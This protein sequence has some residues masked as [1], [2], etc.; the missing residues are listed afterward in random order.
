[1]VDCR[2]NRLKCISGSCVTGEE[3]TCDRCTF[4]N[5]SGDIILNSNNGI[6]IRKTEFVLCTTTFCIAHGYTL[7]QTV[8]LYKKCKSSNYLWCAGNGCK[9]T[10]MCCSD[11]AGKPYSSDATVDYETWKKAFEEEESEEEE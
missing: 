8:V 10:T 9:D 7:V 5:C 1:M 11:C 3:V 2:F 6:R 4:D